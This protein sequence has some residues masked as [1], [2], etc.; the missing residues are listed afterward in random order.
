[1]HGLTFLLLFPSRCFQFPSPF[2][3]PSPNRHHLHPLFPSSLPY[4]LDGSTAG[5]A[6]R[7]SGRATDSGLGSLVLDRGAHRARDLEEHFLK[8]REPTDLAGAGR[9]HR[10]GGNNRSGNNDRWGGIGDDNGGLIVSVGEGQGDGEMCMRGADWTS[11]AFQFFPSTLAS[12][13]YSQLNLSSMY[14]RSHS[15]ARTFS[16]TFKALGVGSP[17]PV[18][19][20]G[21]STA[22]ALRLLLVDLLLYGD[23]GDMHAK[24]WRSGGAKRPIIGVAGHSLTGGNAWMRSSCCFECGKEGLCLRVEDSGNGGSSEFR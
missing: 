24:W 1:M 13:P 4:L 6:L 10:D 22:L 20:G 16:S 14:T 3:L 23:F 2:P 9:H 17:A 7:L 8:R 12:M 15:Q 11:I 18:T 5:G 21:A 19:A